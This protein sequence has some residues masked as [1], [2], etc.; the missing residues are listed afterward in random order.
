MRTNKESI[1]ESKD[2]QALNTLIA[3]F[4]E[5]NGYNPKFIEKHLKKLKSVI[6]KKFTY[7]EKPVNNPLEIIDYIDST[8]LEYICGRRT[9]NEERRIFLVEMVLKLGAHHSEGKYRPLILAANRG[10]LQIVTILL[11]KGADINQGGTTDGTLQITALSA[12]V[13]KRYFDLVAFLLT[14]KASIYTKDCPC[15]SLKFALQNEDAVSLDLLSKNIDATDLTNVYKELSGLEHYGSIAGKYIQFLL[16]LPK[17]CDGSLLSFAL[18]ANDAAL[19]DKIM[20]LNGNQPDKLYEIRL[21]SQ[22][23]G[24][25]SFLHLAAEVQGREG[26]ITYFINKYH[27]NL[28]LYT[29]DED[30][31][32][33]MNA[34]TLAA[35]HN[36]LEAMKAMLEGCAKGDRIKLINACDIGLYQKSPLHYAA[37][38]GNYEITEFLLA[39]GANPFKE[40]TD[41]YVPL[42]EVI[43][44]G[45]AHLLVLYKKY[46]VSLETP[47]KLILGVDEYLIC[48]PIFVAIKLHQ[49][50]VLDALCALGINLNEC[51]GD[52]CSPIV[53]AIQQDNGQLDIAKLLIEKYKA[54]VDSLIKGDKGAIRP[55][56]F[57]ICKDKPHL[58]DYFLQHANPNLIKE[59][60]ISP[61]S[62]SALFGQYDYAKKILNRGAI[63]TFDDLRLMLYFKNKEQDLLNIIQLTLNH[64]KFSLDDYCLLNP[65][66]LTIAIL[67]DNAQLLR[68]ILTKYAFDLLSSEANAR[69]FFRALVLNRTNVLKVF[70]EHLRKNESNCPVIESL[71]RMA[72]ISTLLDETDY[73]IIQ[74]LY[75][76]S[77]PVCTNV[78]TPVIRTLSPTVL[79][80]QIS[81]TQ[82][83]FFSQEQNRDNEQNSSYEPYMSYEKNKGVSSHTYLKLEQK[84]SDEEIERYK[85]E[86][87]LKKKKTTHTV[88]S[89]KQENMPKEFT[90]F[91][92]AIHCSFLQ[93]IEK[94]NK[95]SS[96]LWLAIDELENQGCENLT[97]F[98]KDRYTISEQC[99]KPLPGSKYNR[100]F[101]INH[102]K[103]IISATHELKIKNSEDRILLF[104]VKSDD[105]QALLYIGAV[106]RKGGFH[107]QKDK[108]LLQHEQ[109]ERMSVI[110][111]T[112]PESLRLQPEVSINSNSRGASF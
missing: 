42:F 48:R 101:E 23:N 7:V 10:N 110:S 37:Q 98:F 36:N 111:I 89:I 13:N 63:P 58:F 57:L 52:P 49:A 25:R 16:S 102:E 26:L 72:S 20:E 54:N 78:V 53:Y 81:T 104:P 27:P 31:D 43:Y 32:V 40:K 30:L 8:A 94:N 99:V 41:G 64:P 2:L 84:L 55:I 29:N 107:E 19:L 82:H 4:L 87:R 47:L 92:G 61:L 108:K 45:H 18:L 51:E 59:E 15:S 38:N 65:N 39:N 62:F 22:K 76:E 93:Q 106:F 6:N 35:K 88:G 109:A 11:D 28:F 56:H 69:H 91:E 77:I 46:G 105:T 60:I 112:L 73:E 34:F 12:A 21:D 83:C 86:I 44:E 24:R 85:E 97:A 50:K 90:W 5:G 67:E 103:C 95:K 70:F 100:K 3:D 14:K 1:K 96:Y 74:Q 33:E 71:I 75:K 17:R 79:P 80:V 9:A 68:I 66:P